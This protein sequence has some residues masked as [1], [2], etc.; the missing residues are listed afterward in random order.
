VPWEPPPAAGEVPACVLPPVLPVCDP[1]LVGLLPP[2][3][4]TLRVPVPV[5]RLGLYGVTAG[6]VWTGVGL[7]PASVT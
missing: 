1:V 6:V 3:E 7:P 2:T 5:E 4:P